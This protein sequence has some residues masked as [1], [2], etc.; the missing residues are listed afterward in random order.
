MPAFHG[1]YSDSSISFA[2]YAGSGF[3]SLKSRTHQRRSTVCR[4]PFCRTSAPLQEQARLPPH[5]CESWHLCGLEMWLEVGDGCLGLQHHRPGCCK[6]GQPAAAVQAVESAGVAAADAAARVS[7]T[8]ARM[9]GPAGSAGPS[10]W[11]ALRPGCKPS[12]GRQ[13]GC[14]ARRPHPGSPCWE[15]F[16]L[17][18]HPQPWSQPLQGSLSRPI[19]VTPRITLALPLTGSPLTRPPPASLALFSQWT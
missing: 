13:P 1:P 3:Q 11:P 7:V 4:P 17:R 18:A 12:A 8:P 9:P 19:T 2:R 14:R 16:G 10:G 15:P 5:G 6:Q